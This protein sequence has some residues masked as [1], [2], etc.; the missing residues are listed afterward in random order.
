MLELIGAI[1]LAWIVIRFWPALL[2]LGAMALL[3]LSAGAILTLA[4]AAL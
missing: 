2:F 3:F 4:L 1:L